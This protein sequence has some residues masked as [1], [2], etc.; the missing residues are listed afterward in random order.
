VNEENEIIEED[1][2]LIENERMR[3]IFE[4]MT[5]LQKDRYEAFRAAKIPPKK[6]EKVDILSF[7]LFDY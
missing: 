3:L 5:D 4:S 6:V 2:K 1:I 7:S